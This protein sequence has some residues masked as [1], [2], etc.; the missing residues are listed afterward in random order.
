MS[1]STKKLVA[2]TAIVNKS[3]YSDVIGALQQA[4][5]RNIYS[6]SA[7]SVVLEAKDNLLAS[8]FTGGKGL[9][10]EVSEIIKMLV[11]PEDEDALMRLIAEQA[12]LSI[13]GMGSIYSQDVEFV[14]GHDAL[15]EENPLHLPDARP[16]EFSSELV[17]VSCSVQK[18][19]GDN[20]ARVVLEMGA[21]VP[22]ITFGVGTGLRDKLG[23][24]RITIPAEKEIVS[25]L[26]SHYDVEHVLERMIRDGRLDQPG[27]GFIY[28]FEV[29]KGRLNT[30]LTHGRAGQAASVDQIIAAID[31]MKGN[32]EW[33]RSGEVTNRKGPAYDYFG[34]IDVTLLTADSLG[35]DLVKVA[36][37]AGAPGS[38]ISKLKFVGSVPDTH[39]SR[40]RVACNM[41]MNRNVL[42]SVVAA[43]D[44]AG[45]FGD[46]AHSVIIGAQAPKA[47]TYQAQ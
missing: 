13:P 21:S 38:T 31:D 32:I 9:G 19:Q 16:E 7:R 15:A 39:I 40:A 17:G 42:D 45:A 3:L 44:K 35:Y 18:G 26:V 14:G 23:L 4:G 28:M 29:R 2:V 37:E 22:V 34:G 12:R 46:E 11:K 36:M 47:F 10:S 25:F 20:L 33:R 27:K 43:L 6:A 30:K 8:L 5:G 24:M 41:L 1:D